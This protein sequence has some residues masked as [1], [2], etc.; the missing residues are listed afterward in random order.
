M[1]IQTYNVPADRITHKAKVDFSQ[2]CV[3]KTIHIV[4]YDKSL[5]VIAVELFFKWCRVCPTI[6]C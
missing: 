3:Q 2:R 6:S 5:P 4:Q 1:A